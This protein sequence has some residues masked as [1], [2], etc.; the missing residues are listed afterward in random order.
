MLYFLLWVSGTVVTLFT[1]TS[2]C[3]CRLLWYAYTVL[4]LVSDT[5]L[6]ALL[7]NN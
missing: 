1:D 3:G 7:L 4:F 5:Q 6:A 2:Q